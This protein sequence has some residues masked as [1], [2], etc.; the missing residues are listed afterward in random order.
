MEFNLYDLSLEEENK[1]Y[2]Q[3]ESY[4]VS[5]NILKKLIKNNIQAEIELYIINGLWLSQWKKYACYE[6]IKCNLPLKDL[7]QWREIRK[8]NDAKMFKVGNIN[9]KTLKKS[10]NNNIN[11]TSII[12][13]YADFHFITKECFDA[14]SS[15][16]ENK[17]EII[18]FSFTSFNNRLI[19]QDKD[20]IYVIYNYE[21]YFNF[22]LI[23]LENSNNFFY[24]SILNKNLQDFVK[25][26]GLVESQKEINDS[27]IKII[28][29]KSY[30]NLAKKNEKFTKLISFLINFDYNFQIFDS[31]EI[32]K[33]VYYLINKDWLENFKNK[34][35]YVNWLN[36]TNINDLAPTIKNMFKS[37]IKNVSE[38][39]N[40]E[41]INPNNKIFN[42]LK[43][44]INNNIIKF[45]DNYSFINEE[46]WSYLKNIFI[47]PIEIKIIF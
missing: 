42:Y 4:Y 13:P 15:F 17:N 47:L 27:N 34:L 36:Q 37:F 1:L 40:I 45:Y 29:N 25:Q 30:E 3:I 32:Q 11:T 26:I 18:K 20:Q 33:K 44:N 12:N 8:K 41:V 7:K 24:T 2:S 31:T 21:I 43:D 38:N 10:N 19:C 28:F 39:D 16:P 23:V 14:F 46:V 9:N 6:E 5:Q 22:L 35:N